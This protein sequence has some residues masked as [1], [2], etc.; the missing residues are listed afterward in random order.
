MVTHLGRRVILSELLHYLQRHDLCQN[1]RIQPLGIHL[2]RF[3][4]DAGLRITS[5]LT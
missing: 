3:Q 1:S 4:I 2:C 5:W